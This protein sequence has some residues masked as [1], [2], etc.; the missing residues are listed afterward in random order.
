M[1]PR[2]ELVREWLTWASV[3][4]ESVRLLLQRD[5]PILPTGCFHC[6]QA[7][8]KSLKGLLLLHDQRPPRTHDLADLFGLCE[9]H[10][11]G[12]SQY[13]TR[14]EWLTAW[15]MDARYPE[16]RATLTPELGAEALTA[17]EVV[18]AFVVGHMPEETH[19]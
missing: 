12:L 19:P 4:L 3:D 15:A 1:P 6:Q 13:E 18:Y 7:I 5:P 14:C 11:P 9:A 2:L 10:A 8:E 16:T 17:A